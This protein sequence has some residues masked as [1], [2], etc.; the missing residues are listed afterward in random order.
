M[1]APAF[2]NVVKTTEW[3][4]PGTPPM[5]A[6]T[7]IV[8]AIEHLIGRRGSEVS[9][10][11][12]QRGSWSAALSQRRGD[13]DDALGDPG[14]EA[15]LSRG[16]AALSVAGERAAQEAVQVL[17]AAPHKRRG[18][19]PRG[20]ARGQEALLLGRVAAAQHLRKQSP[21]PPPIAPS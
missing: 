5:G 11:M 15:A 20:V 17:R 1:G 16:K 10:E 13:R 8:Q 14:G 21:S 12:R 19:G 2:A 18:Q 6:R 4:G 3:P 7:Q 9:Q